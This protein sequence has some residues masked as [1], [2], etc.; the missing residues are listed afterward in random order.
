MQHIFK[1]F[2]DQPLIPGGLFALLLLMFAMRKRAQKAAQPVIKKVRTMLDQV[3]FRWSAHDSFRIRDLLNGGCLILGRAGSGKTSSSGRTLMQSIVAHPKSGGLILAAKPEDEEDVRR[4]FRKAGREEDLIVFD[5]DQPYRFNFL[6]YVGSRGDPRNLVR[7]M[8]MI[9]ETLQR[10]EQ[11][12]GEDG[13]FWKAQCERL[14]ETAVICLQTAGEEVSAVNLHRFI[15]NRPRPGVNLR[16]ESG[17][18]R[19]CF[20]P[21]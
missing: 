19:A 2:D 4:V 10:G 3:L 5:L 1:L 17:W 18:P 16:G 12:G 15:S 14:L 20:S 6:R 7:C 8:M 13:D 9:G 11:G 21:T